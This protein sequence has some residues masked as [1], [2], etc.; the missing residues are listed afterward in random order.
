MDL[1]VCFPALAS[2]TPADQSLKVPANYPFSPLTAKMLTKVRRARP[3]LHAMRS[4]FTQNI[5]FVR[6]QIYHPNISSANGAIC[7]ST[8]GR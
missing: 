2:Y 5:R 6:R 8:L 3:N 7:L 1:R 4:A